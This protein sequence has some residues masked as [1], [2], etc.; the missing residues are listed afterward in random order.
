MTFSIE[1][2]IP[3][4]AEL[5]ESLIAKFEEG[6]LDGEETRFLKKLQKGVLLLAQNPSHPGLASHEIKTLTERCKEKVFQSYLENNTPAAARMFWVYGPGQ[7]VITIIG[8]EA[9]PEPGT[10]S[11]KRVTLSSKKPPAKGKGP[12]ADPKKRRR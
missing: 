4:T 11:Y 9:H 7:G 12:T 3:E 2:G 6:T 1:M 5:W 8:V 10:R